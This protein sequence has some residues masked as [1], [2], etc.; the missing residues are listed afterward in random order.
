MKLVY[1]GMDVP[2]AFIQNSLCPIVTKSPPI[3]VVERRP[4]IRL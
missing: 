4:P 2:G 1:T 3:L